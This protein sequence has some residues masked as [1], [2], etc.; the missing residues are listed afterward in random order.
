MRQDKL[1]TRQ[2]NHN[3]R[4]DNDKTIQDR[5]KTKQ[6]KTRQ[7]IH[8]TITRS[9]QR[10]IT[11]QSRDTTN[12]RQ[13]PRQSQDQKQQM[14]TC[15][16]S[17]LNPKLGTVSCIADPCSISTTSLTHRFGTVSFDSSLRSEASSSQIFLSTPPSWLCAIH[18]MI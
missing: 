1:T 2:D 8:K 10:Q 13:K 12:R 14:T 9:V 18:S 7:G 17:D 15:S 16:F 6:D 3:T 4:Q 11:R 5:N